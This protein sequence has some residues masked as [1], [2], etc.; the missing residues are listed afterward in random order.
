MIYKF[1]SE[2]RVSGVRAEVAGPALLTIRE[3]H[4]TLTPGIVVQEA[5]PPLH[6]LHRAFEWDNRV[7]AEEWR[8]AQARNLIKAIVVIQD[9]EPEATPIRLFVNIAEEEGQFYETVAAAYA[10]RDM[11]RRVL[12]RAVR[13]LEAWQRRYDELSEL[14]EVF[15]AARRVRRRVTA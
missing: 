14:A 2:A 11:R 10:D 6:P 12:E 3:R 1:R 9:D 13:D 8:K 15:E 5:R 7:A 4:G